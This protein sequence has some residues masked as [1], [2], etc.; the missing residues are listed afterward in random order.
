M[1]ICSSKDPTDCSHNL[2]LRLALDFVELFMETLEL[3]TFWHL[4]FFSQY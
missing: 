1:V 4:S 3:L 2:I